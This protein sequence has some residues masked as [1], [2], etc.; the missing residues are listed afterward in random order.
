MLHPLTLPISPALVEGHIPE[1][2]AEQDAGLAA[3]LAGQAAGLKAGLMK[4]P[5]AHCS[6]TL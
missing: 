6:K 2:A 1:H 4:I 3:E 5:A